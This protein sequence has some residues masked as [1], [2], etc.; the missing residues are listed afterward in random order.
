L[1]D[2]SP[3]TVIGK[4]WEAKFNFLMSLSKDGKY[5][6]LLQQVNQMFVTDVS[7]HSPV[8]RKYIEVYFGRTLFSS[9]Q[10]PAILLGQTGHGP[11]H[12]FPSRF[13]LVVTSLFGSGCRVGPMYLTYP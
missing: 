13:T 12:G 5:Q 7:L 4:P 3:Q 2:N 9:N 8:L 10:A 11:T 6:D 1:Q